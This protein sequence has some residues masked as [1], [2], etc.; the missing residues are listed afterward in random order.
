MAKIKTQQAFLP[1]TLAGCLLLLG[2][3]L[4]VPSLIKNAL[5]LLA[6]FIGGFHQTKEGLAELFTH[7]TF[8]VDLLMAL[9]AL[10]ACS[11]GN[12]LEGGILT[13][14]FS[15]AGALEAYT[16]EKS[17]KELTAL[18]NLQPK[19]A[20]KIQNGKTQQVPV[21]TLQP[22]DILA[23][24]KGAQIPTDGVIL[25]GNGVLNE[26]AV[27]GESLPQEKGFGAQ[28][29]GG[30]I[31]LGE[32][33]VIEVNQKIEETLFSRIVNLVKTAQETPSETA[34]FIEKIENIYVKVV[35]ITVPLLICALYF[36]FHWTLTESFYRGMVL[37][38]VAS[39]CA[40]VASVTPATLSAISN[41]AKKGLI[42]KGG[43]PLEN[44]A[45]LK[46][47]A[48]DKTGTLTTG[49]PQVTGY[50]LFSN[51]STEVLLLESLAYTLEKKST[52]PL[53]LALVGHLQNKALTEVALT[54][55]EE[56]AGFGMKGSF[57]GK[58]YALG[59]LLPEKTT[60]LFPEIQAR[61]KDRQKKGE[62]I[63]ALYENQQI[64]GYYA[65][66]DLP[67]QE[68]REMVAYFK[69]AAVITLIFT[70]DHQETGK[71]V[72]E[73]VGIGKVFGGL[74]P[75]DKTQLILAEKE[76]LGMVAMVGD[77]INDAPAL[78]NASIGIAMGKGS[79]IAME[80][81]DI[82][83]VKDQLTSLI[84]AHRLA[85]K[86]KTIVWQN[87]IFSATVI[88]L[89]IASNF[90]KWI[91]LPLGVV[92]HEGST[93]LVILNGLRLLRFK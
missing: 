85:K 35:L 50:E 54:D 34:N 13:F 55:C 22:G 57:Q 4:P 42:F 43:V 60:A 87:I 12:F 28:V 26:A 86:L 68:A 82:V 61:L 59:K 32:P 49:K 25:K 14:I 44:L 19:T 41:G 24:P 78:A 7:K 66:L 77:G 90:F 20:F 65:L 84:F 81:A 18:L 58:N 38:V 83:V 40:L 33:L 62:T 88:L 73:L 74:L 75:E 39:P 2:L 6:I 31:N 8:N 1:P 72:G 47:I 36:I 37:L 69:K 48:F 3:F 80:V 92:G 70:G 29:Y 64:I 71:T 21:D 27:N 30:T 5:F 89:L 63:V 53:A 79:D 23:V 10:G 67:R 51:S 11:I 76:K 16:L 56:V 46:G 93:L 9:A 17:Q 91:D 45:S 52:H 15:L